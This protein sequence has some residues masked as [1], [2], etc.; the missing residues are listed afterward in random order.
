M[1][2][3]FDEKKIEL[4][5]QNF[6]KELEAKLKAKGELA[7]ESEQDIDIEEERV[8]KIRMPLCPFDQKKF[9][10]EY[11]F[12]MSELRKAKENDERVELVYSGEVKNSANVTKVIEEKAVEEPQKPKPQTKR[13]EFRDFMEAKRKT[14]WV[15]TKAPIKV[16]VEKRNESSV[17]EKRTIKDETSVV[18]TEKIVQTQEQ[19]PENAFRSFVRGKKIF[20]D[21]ERR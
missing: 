10:C 3:A 8:R 6:I 18:H 16:K 2:A 7:E 19:K 14:T 4:E 11:K 15:H 9:D 1:A 13:G 21:R 12:F 17:E 20:I 5:Y